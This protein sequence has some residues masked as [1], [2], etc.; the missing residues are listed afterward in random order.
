MKRASYRFGVEHIALNDEPAEMDPTEMA[1]MISVA[2]LADLFGVTT[3][4]VAADVIRLRRR[5]QREED[6]ESAKAI[7][8]ADFVARDNDPT[9]RRNA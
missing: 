2:L 1:S 3:E 4:R 7:R 6:R 5:V 9:T 8:H